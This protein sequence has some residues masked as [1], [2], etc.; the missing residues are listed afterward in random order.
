M[1]EYPLTHSFSSHIAKDENTFIPRRILVLI[2]PAAG[3]GKG[4]SLFRKHVQPMFEMAE[5]KLTVVVTGEC[6]Q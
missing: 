1:Y 2:N 5:M 6:M 3:K 4:E